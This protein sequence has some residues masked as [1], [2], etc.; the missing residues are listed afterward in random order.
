[1][2]RRCAWCGRDLSG[3]DAIER[4]A[5]RRVTHGIC[6]E[7][8][9]RLESGAGIPIE[10]FVGSLEEP[11]MLIDGDHVV[12]MVN[13]A[14]E[15]LLN[16]SGKSVVGERAGTVFDCEN[17]HLPGGCGLTVHCSGCTIRQAVAFTHHTG[18]PK[19]NVPATLRVV[20]N[21]NLNDV[22]LLISTSR[23]GNRVLLK[24]DRY[25]KH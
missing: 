14:A 23:V 10:D 25:E 17:A 4:P 19:L 7:C 9:T 16:G 6:P 2:E 13:D 21:A 15:A 18:E 1:M 24:I 8:R 3:G 22:E 5:D 20:E 12:G 11:V